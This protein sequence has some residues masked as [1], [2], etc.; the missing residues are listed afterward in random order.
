[1]PLEIYTCFLLLM[2]SKP[3]SLENYK[4]WAQTYYELWDN[5]MEVLIKDEEPRSPQ[6]TEDFRRP[7]NGSI[8]SC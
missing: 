4:I 1:M 3:A 7:N 8:I 2:L 6:N 5:E